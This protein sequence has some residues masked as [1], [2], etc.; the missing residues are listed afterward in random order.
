MW[1]PISVTDEA[2]TRTPFTFEKAEQEYG[3]NN[4]KT[5]F[6]Y[7]ALNRLIQGS[8]ADQTKMAM[9]NLH[10]EGLLPLVQIHDE[11]AMSVPN[12]E[13]ADKIK[14]IMENSVRLN[15]PSVVD[16]EFGPN[17]GSLKAGWQPV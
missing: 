12:K 14:E 3:L 1:E 4:I 7:K 5:A 15:V 17:W 9:V 8:A 10:K 11:L 2:P 13:T 6:A 16:A